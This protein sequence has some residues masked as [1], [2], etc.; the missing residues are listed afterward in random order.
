MII[1]ERLILRP[2]KESDRALFAKLNADPEVMEFFPKTLTRSESDELVDRLAVHIEE[3]GWGLFAVELKETSDFIGTIGIKPITFQAHFTPAVE[4]GWRLAKEYWGK[5]YATEG[6]KASLDYGF[7][8]LKL[9]KIVSITTLA[10]LRSQAVMK[11]LG[12]KHDPKDNF[13]HPMLP[14]GHPM[15]SHVLYTCTRT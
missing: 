5:G 11:K 3:N 7:N 6:A 4:V 15:Q 13:D 8:V 10:N 2:W 9:E 12:M 14:D 1:T